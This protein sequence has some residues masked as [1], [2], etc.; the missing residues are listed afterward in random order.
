MVVSKLIAPVNG[1]GDL[2]TFRSEAWRAKITAVVLVCLVM[3]LAGQPTY[4]QEPEDVIPELF[5]E[6]LSEKDA[7]GE[8]DK[9]VIRNRVVRVD[10]DLLRTLRESEGGVV[11][12]NLFNNVRFVAKL[13]TLVMGKYGEAIWF[14]TLRETPHGKVTLAASDSIAIV[15]TTASMGRVRQ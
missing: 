5:E 7:R 14:G 8:L 9:T 12:F 3:L 2:Y 15:M 6:I 1:S 11:A 10:F 13:D 4:G